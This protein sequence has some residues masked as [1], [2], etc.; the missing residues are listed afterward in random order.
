MPE[1]VELFTAKGDWRVVIAAFHT[2]YLFYSSAGAEVT[3]Y[4]KEYTRRWHDPWYKLLRWVES[5]ANHIV[6]STQYYPP[7]KGNSAPIRHEQKRE[8]NSSS[9]KLKLWNAGVGISVHASPTTGMPNPSTA[10]PPPAIPRVPI[11]R[12]T[13]SASVTIGTETLHGEVSS[14]R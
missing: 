10:R 11:I 8:K 6:L 14:E 13:A 12:V 9:C 3:V 5:P 4:H 7:P 2:N 1:S